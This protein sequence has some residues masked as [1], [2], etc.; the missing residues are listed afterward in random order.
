MWED[1]NGCG[2]ADGSRK[3]RRRWEPVEEEGRRAGHGGV[4]RRWWGRAASLEPGQPFSLPRPRETLRGP[5]AAVCGAGWREWGEEEADGPQG[6][7]QERTNTSL[8][9]VQWSSGLAKHSQDGLALWLPPA[10]SCYQTPHRCPELRVWYR[11]CGPV[12]WHPE[13]EVWRGK[14]S[15]SSSS[16]NQSGLVVPQCSSW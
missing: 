8:S 5:S 4:S 13:Q 6:A 2:V 9:T 3:T 16:I 12:P 1:A 10:R 11:V 14:H 7:V 15:S